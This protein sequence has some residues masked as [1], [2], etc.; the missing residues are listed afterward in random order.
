MYEKIIV[1][2]NKH[3]FTVMKRCYDKSLLESLIVTKPKLLEDA[4][5][6]S[7]NWIAI[8][9]KREFQD[10]LNYV[11]LDSLGIPTLVEV[12][13]NSSNSTRR[14]EVVGRLLEYG[15]HIR[16]IWDGEGVDSGYSV[17]APPHGLIPEQFYKLS[18][19]MEDEDFFSLVVK[20]IDKGLF[21]LCVL[22]NYPSQELTLF[23]ETLNRYLKPAEIRC[24]EVNLFC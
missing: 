17:W 9:R 22:T 13:E 21:R 6:G 7:E 4:F 11:F 20:N 15:I 18:K 2:Q 5:P 23:V 8:P 24:L 19:G 1:H 3:D 14:K 16:S 10:S 12:L